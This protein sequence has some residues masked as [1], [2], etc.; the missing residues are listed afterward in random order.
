LGIGCYFTRSVFK[1]ICLK[2]FAINKNLG[3]QINN[4]VAANFDFVRQYRPDENI[5]KRPGGK[6]Y[7][8]VGHHEIMLPLLAIMIMGDL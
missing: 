8:F 2:A 4:F 1:S 5:L 3:N 6:A 7:N